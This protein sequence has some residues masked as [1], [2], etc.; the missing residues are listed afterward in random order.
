MSIGPFQ[1]VAADLEEDDETYSLTLKFAKPR[2]EERRKKT[3]SSV[4]RRPKTPAS[5]DHRFVR[6]QSEYPVDRNP[7][8][9]DRRPKTPVSTN[10]R[11]GR[12]QTEYVPERKPRTPASN[13]SVATGG[14][15]SHADNVPSSD[16]RKPMI[17]SSPAEV[18]KKQ[19][20]REEAQFEKENIQVR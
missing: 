9:P 1:I 2:A 11:L 15:G 12:A 13:H 6:A 3:S 5:S 17:R 20:E 14:W 18:V 7:K 10:H 16:G 8:T 19:V 4:E